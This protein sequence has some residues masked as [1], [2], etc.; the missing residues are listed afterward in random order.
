[1]FYYSSRKAVQ[2]TN[3]ATQ[4]AANQ[5]EQDNTL[6]T[7]VLGFQNANYETTSTA[8]KAKTSSAK[9]FLGA[10]CALEHAV[11]LISNAISTGILNKQ[12]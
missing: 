7:G 3:R 1:M 2:K 12:Y 9:S 4:K 10:A 11:A 5:T 6:K 8:A